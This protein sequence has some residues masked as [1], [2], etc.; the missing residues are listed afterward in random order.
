MKKTIQKWWFTLIEILIV[1]III[2]ILSTVTLNINRSRIS[3]MQALNERETRRDQHNH[4]NREI[5]N[6]NYIDWKKISYMTFNYIDWS[7]V[8]TSSWFISSS[9]TTDTPVSSVEIPL[10]YHTISWSLFI[11]KTPLSLWCTIIQEQNQ[12]AANTW[13]LYFIEKKS[14]QSFCFQLNTSLCSRSKCQ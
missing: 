10:H 11:K 1:I 7:S 9:D 4:L 8:I 3:E 5:T 14:Q 6:T 2:S 13:N 12:T